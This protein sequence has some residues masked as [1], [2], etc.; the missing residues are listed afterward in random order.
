MKSGCEE[1]TNLN[2]SRYNWYISADNIFKGKVKGLEDFSQI[3][4]AEFNITKSSPSERSSNPVMVMKG[5]K[6]YMPSGIHCAMIQGRLAKS[7][8]IPKIILKRT[9]VI[10]GKVEIIDE[11]NFLQCIVVLFAIIGDAV[12]FCFQYASMSYTH[13]ALRPDGNRA[14]QAM[15]E[16]KPRD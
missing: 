5:V 15:A 14:G 1:V 2:A 16:L 10:N 7:I 9:S 8:V 12:S 4:V 3:F 11:I 13:T 6:I